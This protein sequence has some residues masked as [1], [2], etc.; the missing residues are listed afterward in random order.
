MYINKE[1][2]FFHWIQNDIVIDFAV[3]ELLKNTMIEAEELDKENNKEY[4]CV[5]EAIDM[6]CKE[7]CKKRI[8]TKEQWDLICKK[9][10][11]V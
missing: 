10:P 5:A 4:F 11:C 8:L 7:Y 1:I 9:Y 6:I 2:N 3:P